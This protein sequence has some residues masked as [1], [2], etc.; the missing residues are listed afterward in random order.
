MLTPSAAAADPSLYERRPCAH[1]SRQP[2]LG[3]LQLH[4]SV[5]L[6]VD[7]GHHL[8]ACLFAD[9][10]RHELEAGALHHPYGQPDR[11]RAHAAERACRRQVRHPLPCLC[12]RQ[13]R[14][15]GSEYSRDAARPGGLRMVWHSVLAGWPGDRS[16]D[17]RRVAGDGNTCP[18]SYGRAFSASGCSI[19]SWCGAGWSRSASCRASPRPSCW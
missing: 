16:H 10:R 4:R 9:S 7:G 17:P 15:L 18:S 2:H 5:V 13:L 11:A 8:H 6:H 12:A 1:H 3:H 19:C 14:R